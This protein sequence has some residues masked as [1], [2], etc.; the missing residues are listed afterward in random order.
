[1]LK[2]GIIKMS[3]AN[4]VLGKNF[5]QPKLQAQ[6]NEPSISAHRFEQWH[7]RWT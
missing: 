7:I 6:E 4:A 2:K 1:M 5:V 3:S